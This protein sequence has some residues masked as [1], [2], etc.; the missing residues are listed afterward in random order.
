MGRL[1]RVRVVGSAAGSVATTTSGEPS[2]SNPDALVA[3][4]DRLAVLQVEPVLLLLA[5]EVE[6]AVVVDVAVLVDLDEGAPLVVRGGAQYLGQLLLVGVDRA[7]DERR[8]RLGRSQL[9][10]ADDS[11][12][13]VI[14]EAWGHYKAHWRHLL[15]I[16]LVV[17]VAIA[18]LGA[19][20]ALVLGWLGA[21]IAAVISLVGLFLGARCA[22]R[23]GRGH[24]RRPC[25]P[26]ARRHVQ[27][28]PA[29]A[30]SDR[31]RGSPRRPGHRRRA[32][33]PRRPRPRPDDVVGPGHPGGRTRAVRGR[34]GVHSEP[35]ARA[36]VR[37][38]RLR[39]D[40]AGDPACCSGSRSCLSIV[41]SPLDGWL[42]SL[43]STIVSGSLT[44]P[45]I[46][47][48][49]TLL[50]FRLRD[51]SRSRLIRRLLPLS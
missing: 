40:R 29:S 8:L 25:R 33:A 15:P 23:G 7:R 41:L 9:R 38:E 48:V 10:L 45:F 22:G 19:L 1:L 43:V 13:R 4:H 21:L 24:P 42:Q 49:W 14:G 46:A 39:R 30:R 3:P 2:G 32:G 47:L 27:P 28:S 16:A 12:R 17:Y 31:R 50:Y 20:L 44:T 34:G 37:L 5:H 11:D 35:R 6:G 18:I 26:V 51:A 36:R